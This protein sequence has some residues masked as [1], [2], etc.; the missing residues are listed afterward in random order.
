V[1]CQT[2]LRVVSWPV[3][4]P[5]LPISLA[6]IASYL[7]GAIPF[8]WI[9]VR[10]LRGEDLRQHGSGNIGATNAG[11]LLGRGGAGFVFLLD[12]SK[13]LVPVLL[14]APL[15][16][17]AIHCARFMPAH[18]LLPVLCGA[19]AVLGHAFP[20]YLGFKGGKA[21][22]TGAGALTGL[23]PV[24]FLVGGIA[25]LVTLAISRMVSF[26]SIVMGVAFPVAA[27]VQMW[28]GCYGVEVV[29]GAWALGALIL[30]RHRANLSRI[31][32]GTEP[33]IGRASSAGGESARS[34]EQS[35]Q[36]GGD[37]QQATSE[38]DSP[39]D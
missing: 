22:A 34:A 12:F 23:D 31:L 13:G 28:R 10:L 39:D 36:G 16:G 6:L 27:M 32:A 37:Q 4:T 30:L 29:V 21:V 1:A 9:L 15:A 18:H 2:L 33:G 20:I 3:G 38:D 26:A 7:L 11:R 24:L 8:G 5:L 35:R 25:W 14:F 19:A 17:G